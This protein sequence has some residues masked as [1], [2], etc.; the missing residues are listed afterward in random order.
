[1]GQFFFRICFIFAII[2]STHELSIQKIYNYFFEQFNYAEIPSNSRIIVEHYTNGNGT[3]HTIFHS[4]YGRRVNDCLS[5]AIA[6]AISRTQHRDVE[7]GINDNG[8][9]IASEKTVN[10]M[11]AFKLI[12]SNKT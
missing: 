3:K 8:F 4:L 6:F 2:R 12:K 1:M 9:Y 5:R 10:V 11:H 7:I